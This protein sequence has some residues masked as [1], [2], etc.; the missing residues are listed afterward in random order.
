MTPPNWTWNVAVGY[1]HHCKRSGDQIYVRYTK[2]DGILMLTRIIPLFFLSVQQSHLMKV[3]YLALIALNHTVFKTS[4]DLFLRPFLVYNINLYMAAS[5]AIYAYCRLCCLMK[6][7]LNNFICQPPQSSTW[8]HWPVRRLWEPG[9]ANFCS[10]NFQT[11]YCNHCTVAQTDHMSR[12]NTT[13]GV[14]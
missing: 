7:R 4:S 11:W 10:M 1:Q 3:T 12:K 2:R 5:P 13:L 14:L 9:W 6:Q 8:C